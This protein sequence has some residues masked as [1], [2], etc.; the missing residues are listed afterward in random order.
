MALQMRWVGE[1][2]AERVAQTR[3]LCYGH[4]SNQIERFREGPRTDARARGGDYLLAEQD[5]EAVGTATSLSM[6]MWVRGAA[7]PCQGV[8]WVGT[9]KTQR[10]RSSNEEGVATQ[11]M[12]ETLRVA[13]ERGQVVSALM[14]FR[15]SFYEHFGYGLVERRNEWTVPLSLLPRGDTDGMRAF[16][17]DDLPELM[18]Q[19]QRAVERGQCDIERHEA[20]WAWVLKRIEGGFIFVDRLGPESGVR[21]FVALEHQQ[22][23]GKDVLR[24]YEMLTDD[25]AALMRQLHFLASLK[26]QYAATVLTLPVDVPLNWLLRETQV[27]HRLVNHP[28]AECRTHTRMQV[29]V[30]D[31]RRFIEAL[32]LPGHVK[33]RV[34][35]QILECEGHATRLSIE[36]SEGRAQVRP[37]QS[38]AGFTCPDRVWA[39]VVCGDL[40]ATAALRLAMATGEEASAHLLGAF[41]AGPAPFCNE[42]F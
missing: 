41:C 3:L 28:H 19:R 5:G 23:N 34:D 18:K 40:T 35:V 26:D 16:K 6:K 32:H 8:A 21:G 31:H 11:I 29:R 25:T 7:V 1:D 36:L 17:P 20:G 39:A 15:A 2:E 38:T 42:Y 37:S 4:G 33:G 12:R 13:R 24:V 10:R 9:I 27:P 22:V 30:L 14:P